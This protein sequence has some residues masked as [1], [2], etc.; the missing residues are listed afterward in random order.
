MFHLIISKINSDGGDSPRITKIAF[1]IWIYILKNSIQILISKLHIIAI[2]SQGDNLRDKQKNRHNKNI[3]PVAR[4]TI[5]LLVWN[6]SELSLHLS[7]M[8]HPISYI[9]LWLQV[10]A[11]DCI[12][13]PSSHRHL[14]SVRNRIIWDYD[15][16]PQCTYLRYVS[17]V[18]LRYNDIVWSRMIMY[19]I[20][21]YK[22][23]LLS[24]PSICLSVCQSVSQSVCCLYIHISL[25][26]SLFLSFSSF[27]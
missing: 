9:F 12:K 24:S 20:N 27:H 16:T 8:L 1:F 17:V 2:T 19:I 21:F 5:S 6:F 26:S 25:S 14:V 7:S 15:F 10:S 18:F 11:F 23:S 13:W 3:R 4:R 22:R